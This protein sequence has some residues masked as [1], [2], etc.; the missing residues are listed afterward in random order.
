[1]FLIHVPPLRERA[2][3]IPLLVRH[4]VQHFARRMNRTIDTISSEACWS[5]SSS[6]V[7]TSMNW[8]IDLSSFGFRSISDRSCPPFVPV[9]P[10][11]FFVVVG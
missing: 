6:L 3:D 8:A 4:F 10:D 5:A 1:V 7:A 11:Q 2:E 9:R